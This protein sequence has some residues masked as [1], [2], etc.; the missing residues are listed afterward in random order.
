M[1]TTKTEDFCR[2][3]LQLSVESAKPF[4]NLVMALA[5]YAP[6][7][8]QDGQHQPAKWR[9]CLPGAGHM[10]W[11]KAMPDEFMKRR[12][13]DIKPW[14]PVL[15]GRVVPQPIFMPKNW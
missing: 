9:K 5:S 7:H 14:L 1:N 15:T 6:A 11:T 4:A 2:S 8:T 10:T 3:I 13:Y 12:G